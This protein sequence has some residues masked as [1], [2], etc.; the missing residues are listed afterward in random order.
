MNLFCAA[1]V[2]YFLRVG[3]DHPLALSGPVPCSVRLYVLERRRELL[4]DRRKVRRSEIKLHASMRIT[5]K[6]ERRRLY[7]FFVGCCKRR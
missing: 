2:F 1:N 3:S 4:A 6:S 7:Y 5:V